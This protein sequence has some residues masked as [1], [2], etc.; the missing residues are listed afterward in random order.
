MIRL[1]AQRTFLA[2]SKQISEVENLRLEAGFRPLS[3]STTAT[4]LQDQRIDNMHHQ[5]YFKYFNVDTACMNLMS[6]CALY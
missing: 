4:I 1:V 3:S 5:Y 2:P 6:I